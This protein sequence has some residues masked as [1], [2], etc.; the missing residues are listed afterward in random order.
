MIFT[1]LVYYSDHTEGS[2]ENIQQSERA[3]IQEPRV[4]NWCKFLPLGNP[5]FVMQ[6][7]AQSK[8]SI[9]CVSLPWN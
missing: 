8:E 5:T 4:A 7:F 2:A 9:L 6:L 1:I 3:Q